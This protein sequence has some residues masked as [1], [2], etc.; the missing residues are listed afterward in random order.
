MQTVIALRQMCRP[1]GCTCYDSQLSEESVEIQKV[2]QLLI[3]CERIIFSVA[4]AEEEKKLWFL[5]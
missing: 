5:F 4:V 1:M 2:L 3:D